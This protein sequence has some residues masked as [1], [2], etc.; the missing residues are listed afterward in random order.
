MMMVEIG[1]EKVLQQKQNN[2]PLTGIKQFHKIVLG[3]LKLLGFSR[4]QKAMTRS[5]GTTWT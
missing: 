5:V 4:I 3:V 1:G 2:D